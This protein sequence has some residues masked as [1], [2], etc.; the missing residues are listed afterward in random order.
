M[1]L[2]ASEGALCPFRSGCTA[3]R[4]V[5]LPLLDSE[6][7]VDTR[8]D[9]FRYTEFRN[10]RGMETM[11]LDAECADCSDSSKHCVSGHERLLFRQSSSN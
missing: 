9:T 4:A 5:D 11:D 10:R 6:V 8:M 3:P 1:D 2:S 7:R